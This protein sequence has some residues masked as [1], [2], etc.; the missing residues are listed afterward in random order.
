MRGAKPDREEHEEHRHATEH[1]VQ[2][3]L[4]R[5][6][7]GRQHLAVGASAQTATGAQEMRRPESGR[8]RFARHDFVRRIARFPTQRQR[9]EG[10]NRPQQ[11]PQSLRRSPDGG[12]F[13]RDLRKGL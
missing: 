5:A 10:V 12:Q 11:R 4:K 9:P 13:A 8:R 1:D 3:S 7:A 2:V 6:P